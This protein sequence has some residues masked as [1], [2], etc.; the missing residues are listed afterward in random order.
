MKE[1]LSMLEMLE[2]IPHKLN[3]S[4][5]IIRNLVI[6]KYETRYE[7][8]YEEVFKN[9]KPLYV[10]VHD[11]LEDCIYYLYHELKENNK[12]LNRETLE[13]L[14]AEMRKHQKAYFKTR[15]LIDLQLSK[16]FE[17]KV[18]EYID[19]QRWV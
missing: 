8:S 7:C 15:S 10:T 16:D 19:S 1:E 9:E 13:S 17:K 6:R 3:C 12:L 14:I 5:G 11:K 2:L 18:D 4:N